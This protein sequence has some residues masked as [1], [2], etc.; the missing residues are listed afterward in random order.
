MSALH[1]ESGYYLHNA[2]GSVVDPKRTLTG[3]PWDAASGQI[4]SH[5]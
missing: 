1:L 5:T 4:L 3:R 2:K